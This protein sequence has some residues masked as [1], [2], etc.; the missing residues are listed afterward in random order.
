M[1]DAHLHL[2]F[3][4]HQTRKLPKLILKHTKLCKTPKKCSRTKISP[5]TI[6]WQRKIISCYFLLIHLIAKRS[7]DT[8]F[9]PA[10]FYAQKRHKFTSYIYQSDYVL[11][12][13]IFK[14]GLVRYS[15]FLLIRKQKYNS[16][17]PPC[18]ENLE[19]NKNFL[20]R[21]RVCHIY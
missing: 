10:I 7:G 3:T 2:I 18:S 15:S 9:F 8:V 20:V 11:N 19:K 21:A 13:M 17:G 12:N 5:I 4:K 14:R 6:C 16:S 1:E